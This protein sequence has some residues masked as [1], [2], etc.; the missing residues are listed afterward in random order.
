MNSSGDK[1]RL[2]KQC[3]D[4]A[5]HLEKHWHGSN[6]EAVAT[7]RAAADALAVSSCAVI[8]GSVCRT[9]GLAVLAQHVNDG[10]LCEDYS[11]VPE[12][13]R[14]VDP[15]AMMAEQKDAAVV[16]LR[17]SVESGMNDAPSIP[18][19]EAPTP[20]TDA[21]IAKFQRRT[22]TGACVC[23]DAEDM[24]KLERELAAT[25]SA[26]DVLWW[27]YE[28]ADRERM[29]LR[30]RSASA[31][32]DPWKEAVID[33]LI[34]AHIYSK[35]DEE[36]PRKALNKLLAWEQSVALD[37][38][39]SSAAEALIEQGR[40]AVL[41]STTDAKDAAR[42]RFLRDFLDPKDYYSKWPRWTVSVESGGEGFIVRG[43]ELDRR[44][45]AVLSATEEIK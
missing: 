22:Y 18:Q 45:D 6:D 2:V 24:A 21:A 35:A 3:R 11:P 40:Q 34:C 9:H 42:Y 15:K 25:E 44:L 32:H 23:V 29:E 41:S 43:E 7:L 28:E 12:S 14:T 37:P 30:Q 20:R 27:Q 17:E 31:K 38:K 36:D 39:V 16:A 5:E 10:S 19:P 8:N 1:Q 26:R 4:V 33:G 13:G